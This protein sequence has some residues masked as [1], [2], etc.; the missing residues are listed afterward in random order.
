MSLLQRALFSRIVA[1]GIFLASKSGSRIPHYAQSREHQT[2]HQFESLGET[3]DLLFS[4]FHNVQSTLPICGPFFTPEN[5]AAH[6]CNA[7][8]SLLFS[9]ASSDRAHWFH[10]PIQIPK[11][12]DHFKDEESFLQWWWNVHATLFPDA[13]TFTVLRDPVDVIVSSKRRWS[14][15]T[16]EAVANLELIYRWLLHDSSRCE[17]ALHFDQLVASPESRASKV[18]I[19]CKR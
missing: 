4:T 17:F 12:R 5:A 1:L 3:G 6:T 14:F 19:L 7:V 8:H 18:L 9:L 2:P 10:K 13:C 15:T 11:V 16:E